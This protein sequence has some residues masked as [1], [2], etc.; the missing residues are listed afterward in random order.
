MESRDH[1]QKQIKPFSPQEEKRPARIFQFLKPDASDIPPLDTVKD[2]RARGPK[3]MQ[4]Q[5]L[6]EFW[7]GVFCAENL[8]LEDLYPL[9]LR[10]A[11]RIAREWCILVGLIE[12]PNQPL[13]MAVDGRTPSP[14]E[15]RDFVP[16]IN[17]TEDPHIAAYYGE[18]KGIPLMPPAPPRIA[19]HR[20]DYSPDRDKR[21]VLWCQIASRIA[22]GRL[23]IHA[24][25]DG[26]HGLAGLLDPLYA[27]LAM[28]TPGELYAFEEVIVGEA[29]GW[30]VESNIQ[31]ASIQLSDLYGLREHEIRQ[32]LAM[33]QDSATRFTSINQESARAVLL[34][35]LE[36][37][38]GDAQSSMNA[39][40]A[41][42]VVREIARLKGLVRG[43]KKAAD[44][45]AEGMVR[46]IEAVKGKEGQKKLPPPPK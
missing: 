5:E 20:D 10:A 27:R 18:V 3:G 25:Q 8:T 2:Q 23:G 9:R 28:P 44:E 40:D 39:R 1:L 38:L 30:L 7:A 4:G 15:H 17:I 33:A 11:W 21:L 13:Q 22:F 36:K 46:I 43:T 32:V 24:R 41:I 16:L 35:R 6:K 42:L 29:L 14:W 45:S 31:E 37:I 26:R 12:Q 34:M 19:K